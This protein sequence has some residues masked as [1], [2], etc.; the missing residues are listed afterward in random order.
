[1]PKYFLRKFFRLI[2]QHNFF[3]FTISLFLTVSLYWTSYN[4]VQSTW[5]DEDFYTRE[6]HRFQSKQELV[7]SFIP[8]NM[9]LYWWPPFANSVYGLFAE[10]NISQQYA[11]DPSLVAPNFKEWSEDLDYKKFI[12]KLSYFNLLLYTITAIFLYIISLKL[13]F[14]KLASNIVNLLFISNIRLWFY[15]QALWPEILHMFLLTSSLLLLVLFAKKKNIFYL[16]TSGV[17]LGYCALVKGIV[18]SY[19]P[20]LSLVVFFLA[21]PR[22]KIQAFLLTIVFLLSYQ[23]VVLPQ[24]YANLKR[25]NQAII[26]TNK[27]T[28]IEQGLGVP[29][30]SKNGQVT[31]K[32]AA[33]I[34]AKVREYYK[35]SS[36][37]FEREKLSQKRVFKYLRKTPFIKIVNKQFYSYS[38]LLNDSFLA[39]GIRVNR[40]E[41]FQSRNSNIRFRIDTI[42]VLSSW[43]L[44][45]FGTTGAIVSL[46]SKDKLSYLILS[47]FLFY[48]LSALLIVNHNSRFFI[49]LIPLLAIFSGKLIQDIINKIQIKFGRRN[50]KLKAE[51]I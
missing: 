44:L 11:M 30:N 5:G 15:I 41:N 4:P 39:R 50:N 10:Q 33:Y 18:S 21:N 32:N 7:S 46:F 12:K 48:Y 19:V 20:I 45:I 9:P 43:V 27:W 34:P 14:S 35:S 3:I 24:K 40:W 22:K 28:N 38:R 37:L 49:P 13:G 26:S 36:D 23:S 42:S 25:Y 17:L 51:K 29:A 1:M 47:S 31:Y 8:G 2:Y 6:S 16:I